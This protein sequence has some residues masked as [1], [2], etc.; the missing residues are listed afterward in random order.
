MTNKYRSGL[1][2]TDTI[3]WYESSGVKLPDLSAGKD[4]SSLVSNV[5]EIS[6]TTDEI[7]GLYNLFSEKARARAMRFRIEG[8]PVTWF[9]KDSTSKNQIPTENLEEAISEKHII[10]SYVSYPKNPDTGE[11]EGVI[12]LYK[13]P[14]F[15]SPEVKRLI[16]AEGLVHEIGHTIITPVLFFENYKLKMSN[17]DIVNGLDSLIDFANMAEKYSPISHY[18]SLFRK[19]FSDSDMDNVKRGINEEMAESLAAHLLGFTY[20]SDSER[21]LN[22]FLGRAEVKEYVKKFL[23]AEKAE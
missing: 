19:D 14:D 12:E 10:P 17:G 8:K 16:H 6:L 4:L 13:L 15:I 3:N 21:R 23:E 1:D 7:S 9:H 20:T 18:S 22:P 5:G 11:F 2:M